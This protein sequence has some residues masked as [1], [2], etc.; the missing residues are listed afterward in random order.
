MP[1]KT[2]NTKGMSD[3]AKYALIGTIVT[4]VI[5]LIG[6]AVT[7]YFNYLE[8]IEPQKLAIQATQTAEARLTHVA[9]S[10]TPTFSPTFTFTP[11]QE[12]THTSTFTA[13][14]TPILPD[15]S[16]TFTPTSTATVTPTLQISGEKYCVDIEALNVRAGPGTI[17]ETVGRLNKGDCLTFDGYIAFEGPN[18]W[19]RISPNQAG[20]THLGESWVWGQYLRPQDF[21]QRLPVLTPPP[22]P[23]TPTPTPSG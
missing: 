12:P 10:I 13:S 5:G 14:P 2:E 15:P 8:K 21:E 11:T 23:P 20:F 6:T 7:L 19:L 9:L 17:Y 22:L 18:Y 4:A 16:S 1:A 3:G